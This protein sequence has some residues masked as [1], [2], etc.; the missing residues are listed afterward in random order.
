[1][2][3]EWALLWKL[4]QTPRIFER[5][6]AES[7]SEL[8]LQGRL[9]CEFPDD[10]VRAALTLSELRRKAA[11]KFSRADSMWFDRR[12][13]EQSTSETVARHK[14]R[15]FSGRVCDFCTGIGS[16]AIALAAHCDVIGVDINP[17]QCLRARWNAATYG[18]QSRL[19]VVCADVEQLAFHG[20]LLHV[21]PDRRTA[22][23]GSRSLR[24]EDSVPTLEALRQIMRGFDGGAIKLSPASNFAGK[25]TDVEIEL[26]S[27]SGEAKEATIWFG[28]PAT[29][30][31]WRA[32]VLPA[33]VTLAGDPLEATAEIAPVGR[34]VYDPDPAVVRAGLIDL[35]A[36]QTGLK[37][38][39][40]SEEYLTSDRLIDSPF[41][42]AFEILAELPN[43]EREIRRFF[44]GANFGQL[45]VK[46]RHI[47]IQ[48]DVVR[49]RLSL[50]GDQP[51]VLM[52][53]RLSGKARVLVCRRPGMQPGPG[54]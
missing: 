37:R 7:A 21:D 10:V 39:D 23:D 13:L 35:L 4:R 41:V 19:Q 29:P 20:G 38:L 43:N 17:T 54:S 14:A 34:Y 2:N 25:F 26:V 28:E 53:A 46:C 30:G 18:V 3:D 6:E 45:E 33:D 1:M 31:L 11:K 22:A 27:L 5:L 24:V 42:T 40:E 52:F 36:E 15:R 16:D 32:T 48:A 44:R 51:G 49:R 12:G 50:E 8:Q 9:R 47:P